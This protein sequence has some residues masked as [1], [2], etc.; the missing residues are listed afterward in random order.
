MMTW[1]R[2]HPVLAVVPIADIII[3]II[4]FFSI[5]IGHP[6]YSTMSRY[7]K[8]ILLSFERIHNL[9]TYGALITH[10]IDDQQPFCTQHNIAIYRAQFVPHLHIVLLVKYKHNFHF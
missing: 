4:A 9:H 8:Y 7:D 3:I 10:L 6:M 5:E 2:Y 1:Y